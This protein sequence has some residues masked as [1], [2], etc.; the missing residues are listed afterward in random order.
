[1]SELAKRLD[2]PKKSAARHVNKALR[3]GWLVNA[4]TRKGYP[5]QLSLGEPLPP[6][7]GLPLPVE[8]GCVTVSGST[9]GNLQIDTDRLPGSPKSGSVVVPASTGDD[10]EACVDGQLLLSEAWSEEL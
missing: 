6:M 5:F 9:D 7:G 3:G 4:E 10:F 2:L 1:M 8:L